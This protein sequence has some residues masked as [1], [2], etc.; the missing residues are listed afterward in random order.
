MTFRVR[1]RV[2]ITVDD[3]AV[4]GSDAGYPAGTCGVITYV[5]DGE[6]GVLF[7]D[8]PSGLA[9]SFRASELEPLDT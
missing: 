9:G 4:D 6:Y 2:R 3:P 1:Q 7:D 5:G 8:D